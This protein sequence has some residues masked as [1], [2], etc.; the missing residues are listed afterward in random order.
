MG[1]A[2]SKGGAAKDTKKKEEKPAEAPAEGEAESAPAAEAQPVSADLLRHARVIPHQSVEISGIFPE[3]VT[4]S[5]I[6]D[7]TQRLKLDPF[8]F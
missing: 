7:G 6:T 3:C 5:P 8:T 2:G 4:S 1:C